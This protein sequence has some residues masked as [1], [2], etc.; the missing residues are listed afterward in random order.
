MRKLVYRFCLCCLLLF[1]WTAP[2]EVLYA[3]DP[4]FSQFGSAPLQM[5]PAFAGVN[6]GSTVGLNYRNQWPSI[7]QAYVTYALYYDHFFSEIN[8]GLGIQLLTDNAGQGMYKTTMVT[9]MYSYRLRLS[10]GWYG[11]LGMEAGAFN[12]EIGWDRLIFPDQIDP[13]FGSTSPGGLPYPTTELPPETLGRTNLTVSLGGLVY[14]DV[15]FAG[16][17]A[18]HINN[19]FVNFFESQDFEGLRLPVRVSLHA[20]AQIPLDGNTARSSIFV[21]PSIMFLKQGDIGQI[22][23]GAH[24]QLK[25][26]I[27][28]TFFRQT[29]NNPDAFILMAGM[30]AG[31]FRV[32]YSFD[33]TISRLTLGSGGAHEVSILYNFLKEADSKYVDCLDFAR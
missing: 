21:T 6:G 27:L 31:D 16:F 1:S 11:K 20:G 12:T 9:A 13:I 29:F 22:N 8:S 23:F 18:K 25:E 17:S 10:R 28:G 26:L 4:I 5:N 7:S 24:F 15:F 30:R 33:A 3:Q 2:L 32:L 19:P 14:N